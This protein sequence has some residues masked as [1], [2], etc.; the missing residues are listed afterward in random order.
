MPKG[1]ELTVELQEQDAPKSQQRRNAAISSPEPFWLDRRNGHPEAH[2][3]KSNDT[4]FLL[5]KQT[6]NC[7]S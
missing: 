7:I 4:R 3:S 1:K 5:A 6:Q 2:C